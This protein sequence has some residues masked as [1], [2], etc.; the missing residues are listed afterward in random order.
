MASR[1][2]PIIFVLAAAMAA[3]AAVVLADAGSAARKLRQ[4]G[5]S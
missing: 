5:R 2:K 1:T 3:L 4:T